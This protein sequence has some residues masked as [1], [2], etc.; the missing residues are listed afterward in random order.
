MWI[1]RSGVAGVRK[2]DI[3]IFS[4]RYLYFYMCGDLGGFFRRLLRAFDVGF[5]AFVFRLGRE[6]VFFDLCAD[7]GFLGF[8]VWIWWGREKVRF[9]VFDF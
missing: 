5:Y 3:W 1:R 2:G 6:S 8:G 7:V 9:L 4:C